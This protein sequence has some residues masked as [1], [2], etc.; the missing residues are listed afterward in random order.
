MPCSYDLVLTRHA[1]DGVLLAARE[2]DPAEPPLVVATFGHD[3]CQRFFGLDPDPG[4]DLAD[5]RRV[6]VHETAFDLAL[7]AMPDADLAE[8]LDRLRDRLPGDRRPRV[9]LHYDRLERDLPALSPD[10][11][12]HCYW[13]ARDLLG[14]RMVEPFRYLRE[15]LEMEE[16]GFSGLRLYSRR[17]GSPPSADRM[18]E[19][20]R[21]AGLE[22]DTRPLDLGGPL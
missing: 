8:V 13:E 21:A 22:A 19:V 3:A 17:P 2:G 7:S 4:R 10:D 5:P 11:T 1:L 6:H 16:P 12:L 15:R 18:A 9:V 20:A 14:E